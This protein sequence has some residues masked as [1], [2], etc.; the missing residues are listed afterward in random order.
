MAHLIQ[1]IDL[2][3]T[4]GEQFE[5]SMTTIADNSEGVC[6]H[7]AGGKGPGTGAQVARGQDEDDERQRTQ[8]QCETVYPIAPSL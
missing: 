7:V 6:N 2:E 8:G 3:R 4:C 5:D 1:H